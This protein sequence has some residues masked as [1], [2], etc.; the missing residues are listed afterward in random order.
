MSARASHYAQP[1][2]H[3]Q[4]RRDNSHHY[5]YRPPSACSTDESSYGGG[6]GSGG[7]GFGG[8][9]YSQQAIYSTFRPPVETANA[10]TATDEGSDVE[11]AIQ[12]VQWDPV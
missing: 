11:G 2:R 8:G 7:G 6:G 9:M 1:A 10:A 5:H 3:R 4:R 12:T